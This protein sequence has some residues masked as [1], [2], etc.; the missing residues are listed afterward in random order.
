MKKS[1][2][3][4][5]IALVTSAALT[6]SSC[7]IIIIN[8]TSDPSDT[9]KPSDTTNS[10]GTPADTTTG[11]KI[12]QSPTLD[13]I[14]LSKEYLD[15]LGEIDLGGRNVVIAGVN[16]E[17][18]GGVNQEM[19]ATIMG[20]N[21]GKRN[22]SFETATNSKLVYSEMA[23]DILYDELLAAVQAGEYYADLVVIPQELLGKYVVDGLLY[24]IS[25]L[26]CDYSNQP[27]FDY[28]AI[29]KTGGSKLYGLIGDAT[30]N[31][32][33]L[34]A[35]YF[36]KE[37]IKNAGLDSPY[38]LVNRGQW[39]LDKL[40]EYTAT[41]AGSE[42]GIEGFV[43]QGFS[44]NHYADT[45]F[46]A[47]NYSLVTNA[48]GNVPV[49]T[50]PTDA[51]EALVKK[52]R[53]MTKS[54]TTFLT[55]EDAEKLFTE[56]KMAFYTAPM[57]RSS[58]LASIE[59]DWGLVPVPKTEA[60]QNA[61]RSIADP[62]MPVLA[63][64]AN[65]KNVEETSKIVSAYFASSLNFL[66]SAYAESQMT[67]YLRDSMAI[68]MV[69][70]VTK[71]AVYDMGHMYSYRNTDISPAVDL[72]SNVKNASISTLRTVVTKS[73]TLT[74]YYN[75]YKNRAANELQFLAPPAVEE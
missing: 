74:H 37:I 56:G 71:A 65:V 6:L 33:Y 7:G 57:S 16:A 23:E 11:E 58:A 49:I 40:I 8:D 47:G 52:I 28:T 27:Y 60:D 10:S 38:A 9:T 41:I 53:D 39:T 4:M 67:Y 19:V 2:F 34:Y 72:L 32:D 51:A 50:T 3:L 64:P 36:N 30:N 54:K 43:S 42:H 63:V 62:S 24:D 75:L 22:T 20:L 69:Y 21:L 35:T 18:F 66:K 1:R 26:N 5:L 15:A 55:G 45:F 59:S 12:N 31:P 29:Q 68:D 73:N 70:L 14:T 17:T 46:F 61:F 13:Y 25:Q 48:Y 44:G